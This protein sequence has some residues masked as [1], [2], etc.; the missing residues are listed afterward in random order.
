VKL[1]HGCSEFGSCQARF[2]VVVATLANLARLARGDIQ[3]C[4][5][6]I[7]LHHLGVPKVNLDDFPDGNSSKFDDLNTMG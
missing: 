6:V 5:C 1:M 4:I 7:G 2:E 3:S